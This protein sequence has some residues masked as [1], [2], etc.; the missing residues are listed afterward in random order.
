M[1]L[2]IILSCLFLSIIIFTRCKFQ[3]ELGEMH[4]IRYFVENGDWNNTDTN[5][6]AVMLFIKAKSV[7]K[8]KKKNKVQSLQ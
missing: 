7:E 3:I 5:K 6:Y 4:K 2:Q 1:R 8:N